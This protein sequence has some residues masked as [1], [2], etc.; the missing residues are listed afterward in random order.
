MTS[1]QQNN[2]K[3]N[4]Q[5][6]VAIMV[7]VF[8]V[9]IISLLVVNYS[10]L[11]RREQRQTLDRQLNTQAQ[12]VAESGVDN[13]AQHLTNNPTFTKTQCDENSDGDP[14]FESNLII[15]AGNL[16]VTCSL[17]DPSDFVL[18]YD[19][20]SESSEIIPLNGNG[21]TIHFV[22][23]RWSNNGTF[24][25]AGCNSSRFPTSMPANC[26]PGLL[27]VD[28][29]DTTPPI[30]QANLL[31]N[32]FTAFFYP[33]NSG[34]PTNINLGRGPSNQ[35]VIRDTNCSGGECTMT[36]TGLNSSSYH[37]RLQSLYNNSNVRITAF[38]NGGGGTPVRLY[39]AQASID[40]TA[41]AVDVIRRVRARVSI[42]GYDSAGSTPTS[43]IG[44]ALEVAGDICKRYNVIPASPPTEPGS[45]TAD[46]TC[47]V[48]PGP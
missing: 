39:G 41:K 43:S 34:S 36:I 2:L 24:N 10:R 27:R 47:V 42:S 37:M 26:T 30:N 19:G 33:E 17:V 31:N 28:L 6:M 48:P 9:L 45:V 25:I 38:N 40:I 46:G 22:T 4:Q 7:A 32:T 44:S 20:V 15:D 18:Q 14:L 35:G 12:Y 11:V 3:Q 21:T 5:G 16:E 8:L 13:I 29:V 1:N 23:I